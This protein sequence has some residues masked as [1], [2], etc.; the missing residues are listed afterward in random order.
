[1]FDSLTTKLEG[2][3]QRLSGQGRI[4]E[5]NVA[6]TMGDVRRALLEADVNYQVARSFTN[7]VKD[8]ALGEE[9]LRSVAPGQLLVKIVYDELV[10]LLGG[11]SKGIKLSGRPPTVIL[12]A[13]LQGS[14]KT[15]FCGK[16]ALHLKGQGRVP[17]LAAA[18]VYRPAAVD[19]LRTLA[20]E[21]EVPVYSVV[22]DT[23][24][25]V[26]DAPRV[27]REA[28]LA[29]RKSA[30]DVV[31]IDTA[32]RLHV[33]QAMMAEVSEI[34]RSVKPSEILF[35]VD[36][37][38]GQDAVNTA[39]EFNKQLDFSGVVLSK[40]DGDTRG[41]AALSIRSVVNKPIKFASTGEKL[42]QLSAFHPDRMAR[43][44]LGMGDVVTLV[45]KAQQ[46]FDQQ[47]AAALR[48]KIR[49]EQFDL[50]DFLDYL[51]KMQAMGSLSDVMG[52]VPG[53]KQ[54]TKNTQPDGDSE[55]LKYM[56][57]V[58]L[59]MTPQERRKPEIITSSRRRRIARGSGLQV[60]DVNDVLKHL[61]TLRKMM[62]SAM[63]LKQSGRQIN[64]AQLTQMM[65]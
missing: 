19:Q 24:L 20:G 13:G 33:D 25:V 22:D 65:R 47:Q 63:K 9:V 7:R 27:A 4:T 1:M 5:L 56:E 64:P 41:G 48:R 44:I 23:G 46:Q 36:S 57:A 3:L 10:T 6:Q 30:Q 2:A 50:Q 60:R 28:V 51:R 21:I 35:V 40:L 38:T 15:T 26:Q 18:D 58:I 12:V 31:I 55:S 32:G 8:K 43:R 53:A 45:E 17:L 52:M 29:A 54:L 14:G 37:M 11:T 59:S 39:W 42:S 62:K 34:K 61:R 49:K 16:L